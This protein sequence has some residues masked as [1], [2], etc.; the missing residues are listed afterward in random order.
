[1][2]WLFVI[3]FGGLGVMLLY[4]GVTQ[5]FLQKR[6]AAHARPVKVEIT[7]SDITRSVSKDTDRSVARNT[8]T[9]TYSPNV[10]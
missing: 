2:R 9:T 6:I 10:R 7:R 5:Y 1:M 8:S 3:L 4:V